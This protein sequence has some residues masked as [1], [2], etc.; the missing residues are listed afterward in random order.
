M[1][2][3]PGVYEKVVGLHPPAVLGVRPSCAHT[4]TSPTASQGLLWFPSHG[5]FLLP[6]SAKQSVIQRADYLLW[7]LLT[8]PEASQL[9]KVRKSH[10]VITIHST[11]PLPLS[12]ML[13]GH[14]DYSPG[15]TTLHLQAISTARCLRR[16]SFTSRKSRLAWCQ[17]WTLDKKQEVTVFWPRLTGIASIWHVPWELR[18]HTEQRAFLALNILSD[19][20]RH[21]KL[22][23]AEFF[24]LGGI[25]SWVSL[26]RV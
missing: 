17:D 19:S 3:V 10:C 22:H 4:H 15:W 12:L 23:R 13:I 25:K 20:A 1:F 5:T 11:H 24:D 21:C 16:C 18:V 26:T 14:N 6:L 8:V 9:V 2:S 7:V